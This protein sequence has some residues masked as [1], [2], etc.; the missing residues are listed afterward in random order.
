V[1]P[2]QVRMREHGDLR[3]ARYTTGQHVE[4][5]CARQL[6]DNT[7]VVGEAIGQGADRVDRGD[8]KVMLK[9]RCADGT[10]QHDLGLHEV[11]AELQFGRRAQRVDRH[12]DA[13]HAEHS[14]C[15]DCEAHFVARR[16]RD[17]APED[18]AELIQMAPAL[19][20]QL[21][22]LAVG[23]RPVAI[24]QRNRI[25]RM[26]L[27]HIRQVHVCLTSSCQAAP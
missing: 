10:D 14:E 17:H 19:C 20:N 3:L 7:W 27:N 26:P 16:N 2:R 23:D 18:D 8:P 11:D 22:Q 13:A 1:D 12:D 6:V 5:R 15:A 21:A 25:S 4:R 9:E 24:D